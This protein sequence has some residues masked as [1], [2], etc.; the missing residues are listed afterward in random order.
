MVFYSRKT[1]LKYIA[2]I[3]VLSF[4][5]QTFKFF[6]IEFKNHTCVQIPSHY[7]KAG[8]HAFVVSYVIVTFVIPTVITWTSFIHIWYRIKTSPSLWSLTEQTQAQQRLLLRMC[9][10]TAAVLTGCWLPSRVSYVLIKFDVNVSF[11]AHKILLMLSMSNSV[12]NPWIYFL[13]NKEYRS[14]F[15]SLFSFCK[16]NA[17]LSPEIGMPGNNTQMKPIQPAV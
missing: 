7:G 17:K 1:L 4:L 5:T 15:F 6:E 2:C 16:R 8:Q 9:V 14:E 10:I 13:S 12:V 3:F 11:E